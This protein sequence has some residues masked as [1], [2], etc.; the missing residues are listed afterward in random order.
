M[1]KNKV[2]S[3][4]NKKEIVRQF[5]EGHMQGLV[6]L[7]AVLFKLREDN[8]ILEIVRQTINLNS[9]LFIEANNFTY[10]KETFYQNLIDAILQLY[11]I[12]LEVQ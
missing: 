2:L 1:V 3:A 7:Y 9:A 4:V 11:G 12:T 5:K 6:A 10:E 8:E